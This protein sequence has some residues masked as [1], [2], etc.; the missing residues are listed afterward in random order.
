M[1]CELGLTITWQK[2]NPSRHAWFVFESQKRRLQKSFSDLDG[3]GPNVHGGT[4]EGIMRELCNAF[5][6]SSEKNPGVPQM[7]RT[8]R[9]VVRQLNKVLKTAGTQNLFSARVFEDL[10]F[11]SRAIA[12]LSPNR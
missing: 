1:P 2:I 6:R 3:T 11:T 8:Y 9:R 10:C 5:V 4:V 12:V 7:M